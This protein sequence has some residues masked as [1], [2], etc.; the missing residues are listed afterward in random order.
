ML[1]LAELCAMLRANFIRLFKQK[2]Q[3]LPECVLTD[4]RMQKS[5]Q[6]LNNSAES[7]L[8]ISLEVGYQS[9][10]N[11]IKTFKSY[12]G[13]SLAKFR[14]QSQQA[15]STTRIKNCGQI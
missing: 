11:F 8:A 6:L 13:V 10:T 5:Q 12:Y 4:L 9:E 7:I 2:T 15:P 1:S 3:Y 14:L